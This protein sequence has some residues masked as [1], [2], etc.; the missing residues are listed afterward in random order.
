MNL[1]TKMNLDANLNS[2]SLAYQEG[3]TRD[4]ELGYKNEL[5]FISI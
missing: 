1:A 4:D 3:S 2:N 5:E